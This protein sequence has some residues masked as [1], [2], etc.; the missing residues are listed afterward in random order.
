MRVSDFKI[1]T[2]LGAAFGILVVV[3]LL[4]GLLS[5]VQL[6]QVAGTTE[7]L[8]TVSM[9]GIQLTGE[10]REHLNDMRRAE[11]R[12]LLSSARKEMKALEAQIAESRKKLEALDAVAARMFA[13]PEAAKSLRAY[14]SHRAAYYA[15]NDLMAPASRAGKQDE[16]TNIYN[17]DSNTAF[18]GALAAVIQLSR[19]SATEATASWERASATYELAR[20]WVVGGMGAAVLLA[21]AL[22][23]LIARSIARPIR[24]AV[25]AAGR[26]AEGDMTG[27][28]E[29]HG[30]DEPA[31]M[32]HSLAIMRERLAQVVSQVRHTSDHFATATAQIA[33][34]N[35]DLS[36][37]TAKQ[38]SAL[39]Q[40]RASMEQLGNTV[41]HNAD[42]ARQ[43]NQLAEAATSVAIKGSEAVKQAGA[44]M[45]DI[46]A[47]SRKIADITGIIDGIAFQ[48]NLLALNAAVEAARA[49]THG[50]G[51]AVVAAEVRTLA[52]RCAEAA[53]DIKSL[54]GTSVEQVRKGTSLVEE[55]GGTMTQVVSSIR[56][57][58]DLM[59]EISSATGEQLTG[60]TQVGGAVTHI[61]QVTQQ[62]AALVEELA[63]AAGCLEAQASHL[64]QTVAVFKLSDA[65]SPDDA[66]QPVAAAAA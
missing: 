18:E 47:S 19:Y 15:A 28:L 25:Q 17:G 29:A 1:S 6:S 50:R 20:L 31:Q 66:L 51:F 35:M 61:D 22:A 3:T 24:T 16:A 12:H 27:T 23:V 43:G 58:A 53:R 5:M 45:N 65:A 36:E 40:T 56:G 57:V 49:G 4:L 41:R 34:G 7:R 26:I 21:A 44:T 59:G 11:A 9:P 42:S 46:R 54:I 52:A 39:Q 14:Q 55:A 30:K 37:R 2:R 32:L 60:V 33:Q 10:L 38:A 48:T 63:S 8:A 62:N 64:V 13:S